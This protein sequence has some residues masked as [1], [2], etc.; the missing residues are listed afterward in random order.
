MALPPVRSYFREQRDHLRQR[1]ARGFKV[2]CE[3]PYARH[4]C[5]RFMDRES[6]FACTADERQKLLE[7]APQHAASLF[8][9][10]QAATLCHD[11]R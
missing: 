4:L 8:V 3:T 1:R 2:L 6:I 5:A 11:G 9:G 10:L 7:I